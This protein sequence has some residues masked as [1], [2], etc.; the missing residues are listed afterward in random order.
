MIEKILFRNKNLAAPNSQSA[1]FIELFFDLVFVYAIT[2]VTASTA[3]HLDPPHVL[4]SILVFWLI[5]W[6]W[7]QFTWALNAANTRL[8]EVRLVMLLATGVAFV[9]A[10]SVESAFTA[11][12]LWFAIPYIIG[13]VIGIGL[14]IRVTRNFSGQPTVI[15]NFAMI[16]L[17]GLFAVLAGALAGPEA[18]VWWW[19]A[20]IFLDMLAGFIGGRSEGWELQAGHFAERHGLIVIIALGE[21]L[22]VAASAVS[23]QIRS[24]DLLIVSGLA[25]LVTCLMWWSYF[26]WIHEHLE[27]K[28]ATVEGAE[29]APAARD[30]YSFIHFPLIC[31]II[32]VA[33]GFEK[34]IAHPHDLL[35]APVAYSL[36][37]G[38]VLYIGFIAFAVW[39]MD[40]TFLLPRLAII[41]FTGLGVILSIGMPP[42][43]AL[44]IMA[45]GLLLLIL[46]EWR[47]CHHAKTETAEV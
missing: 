45:L 24:A 37:V 5:W 30:S 23:A 38:V 15:Y 26:A 28:M 16:S 11:G 40:R 42:F 39:R 17:T 36:G 18:R 41:L 12:V 33:V 46:V 14:Y 29:Q 25:V 9:M 19:L 27:H 13:R 7:T 21:S 2:G 35:S 10:S 32:G 4:R 1:D 34:I 3:H 31:G 47:K 20:A 22:I 6:G 8:A 44:A 43:W